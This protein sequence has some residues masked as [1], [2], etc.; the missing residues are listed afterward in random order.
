MLH[1]QTVYTLIRC[2][3]PQHCLTLQKK[4]RRT[5]YCRLPWFLGSARV[6]F[7]IATNQFFSALNTFSIRKR[8][9]RERE[10]LKL[11]VPTISLVRPSS[12]GDIDLCPPQNTLEVLGQ[13]LHLIE[14][15]PVIAGQVPRSR[16]CIQG[17]QGRQ[18][19]L[20][21]QMDGMTTRS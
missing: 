13:N 2:N 4:N 19:I 12:Y 18:K 20:S 21:P 3:G 9:K 14:R 8:R 15:Q 10:H 5:V 7:P 1:L 6:Q 11:R 17:K 16:A